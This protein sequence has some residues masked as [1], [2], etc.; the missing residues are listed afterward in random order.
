M[1]DGRPGRDGVGGI[2]MG[3]VESVLPCILGSEPRQGGVVHGCSEIG[4][5]A[6]IG[7]MDAAKGLS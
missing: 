2:G 6:L 1:V 3:M 5:G 7:R 4:P